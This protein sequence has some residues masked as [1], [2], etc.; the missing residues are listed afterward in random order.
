MHCI[1]VGGLGFIGRNIIEELRL[2]HSY[3]IHVI[4]DLSNASAASL[5]YKDVKVLQEKYLSKLCPD[6]LEKLTGSRVFYFLAGETRVAESRERPLDFIR[7][8]VV[9]PSEF[10]VRNVRNG[11]RFILVTTAGALYDGSSV[12]S[13]HSRENPLNIYGAT[14]FAEEGILSKLV[15]LQ[16]ASYMQLRMSNVFGPY[17]DKKKSAIHAFCR[18]M[19]RNDELIING[20]GEQERDFVFSRDIAALAVSLI[21]NSRVDNTSEN[22]TFYGARGQY[23]TINQLI[24]ILETAVGKVA[25]KRYVDAIELL[26]TEPRSVRVDKGLANRHAEKHTLFEIALKETFEYCA[27]YC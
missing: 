27:L 8:N 19:A 1:L 12:I 21:S 11:D 16:G 25:K 13:E 24:S 7:A 10:V 5:D 18:A 23:Y 14:K 20:S 26:K 4:D 9:E 17:S 3:K 15:M 22:S 6:Y 2:N